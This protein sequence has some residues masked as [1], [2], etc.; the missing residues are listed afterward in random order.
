M[1]KKKCA[2]CGK[3]FT[4]L[5]PKM[6]LCKK[7]FQNKD[8]PKP[9]GE[10]MHN[11]N[12]TRPSG[13]TWKQDRNPRQETMQ[14]IPKMETFYDEKG[15]LKKEIYEDTAKTIANIFNGSRIM[16]TTSVR[17]FFEAV[18]VTYENYLRDPD[19]E[20]SF[21]NAMESLNRLRPLVYYKQQ[22]NITDSSFTDFMNYYIDLTAKDPKNLK[23]F[24]E[25][26]MS[27]VGY[28]KK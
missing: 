8:N 2:K 17:S 23:G 5:S 14:R 27:I 18:R 4:P 24:K 26:F 22:R 28:M 20:K 16:R 9:G 7:C 10:K 13:G 6:D 21:E 25:L 12:P 1:E 11:P 19:K 3:E 15:T